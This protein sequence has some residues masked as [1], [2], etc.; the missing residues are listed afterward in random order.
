[1]RFPMIYSAGDIADLVCEVGFLPFFK[2]P[3]A[4]FSIEDCTPPE[5]WFTGADGPWEWKAPVMTISG[6]AYG[7]F[8]RGKTG[9]VSA[10]WFADFA[11]YRRN[12]YDFDARCDDGF[13]SYGEKQFMAVLEK[14]APVLSTAL[15]RATGYAG[16][17]GMKGYDAMLTGLQMQTYVVTC[18]FTYATDKNGK[19]YG[20]G[21]AHYTT[22]EKHY[23][24]SFTE[25]VYRISPEES[26]QKMLAHLQKI[27]P[28]AEEKSLRRLLDAR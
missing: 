3:I 6:A 23:G 21:L 15:K 10:E 20:W 14:H 13:A 24:A 17:D 5:L 4:G 9:Y 8:F 1:M 7:K 2:N 12:G 11:N 22:P 27:L 26:Y 18:D 16:R 19:E 28:D 25:R